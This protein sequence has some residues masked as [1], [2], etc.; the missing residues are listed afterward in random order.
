MPTVKLRTLGLL[1]VLASGFAA[2]QT[3]PAPPPDGTAPDTAQ[4]QA[5]HAAMLAACDADIKNLCAGQEGHGVMRCL[6]SNS[7]QL[8]GGCKSALPMRHPPTGTT[9]TPST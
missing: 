1:A 9:P 6:R 4:R 8:S 2:A 7:A 3:P 5:H